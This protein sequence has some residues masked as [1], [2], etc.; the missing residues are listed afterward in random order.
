MA[1]PQLNNANIA[2]VNSGIETGQTLYLGPNTFIKNSTEGFST[3]YLPITTESVINSGLGLNINKN[4][5]SSSLVISSAGHVDTIGHIT[6]QGD[7][8]TSSTVYGN[9]LNINNGKATISDTGKTVIQDDLSIGSSI[10]LTKA[11]GEIWTAGNLI[12]DGTLSIGSTTNS[13]GTVTIGNADPNSYKI[14]LM[15]TGE[16]TAKGDLFIGSN[17]T[18]DKFVVSAISGNVL[19]HGS[20]TALDDLTIGQN[21]FIVDASTGDVSTQGHITLSSSG[22]DRFTVNS[23]SGDVYARGNL[24]IGDNKFNVNSSTGAAITQ[25]DLSI[26][27]NGVNKF[28][29]DSNDGAI[30]GHTS[31]TMKNSSETTMFALNGADINMGTSAVNGKIVTTFD[32][33]VAPP[34]A[35][36]IST[37]DYSADFNSSTSNILTTQSYV[38]KAIWEQTKRI[39][40][41]VGSNDTSLATFSNMFNMAQ[42]LAGNDAVQTLNGLLDTTGE[43]KTSITTVM[44]RAYNPIAVNC[45]PAVWADECPP[46]PIPSS[47]SGSTYGLDGWYFRNLTLPSGPS[48]INW[49]LPSNGTGMKV[50]HILN[51]FLNIYAVSDKSLPFIS[52]MTAP[53]GNN[54]DLFP[55]LCNSLVNFY[56]SASSPSA[57][58]KKSYTLYTSQNE[59]ANVFNSIKLRC[60]QTSAKNGTN[61]TQNNG[62]GSITSVSSTT[63]FLNSFDTSIVSPEDTVICF[64]VQT[65]STAATNDVELVVNSLNIESRDTTSDDSRDKINGTT[66]FMFS[67]AAV[68]TNYQFNYSFNKHI[69]FTPINGTKSGHYFKS[70]NTAF[71]I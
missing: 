8:T 56:F 25:G 54:T 67:N 44:N 66:K 52:F 50:K 24:Q 68:A 65:A 48:K 2:P 34:S 35:H 55:T 12:A 60:N 45:C 5:D 38:D 4:G 28:H 57:T 43:I 31:L 70:Y 29:V 69:D 51:L 49:Y 61:R 20:I 14:Q 13:V 3:N 27:H 1:P 21:K 59:P 6:A 36:D 39:N 46:M 19:T 62:V 53:K 16:I 17:S 22:I 11:D 9:Q 7:I 64:I 71:S 30:V 42:T 33:Y 58:A 63:S 15:N 23:S 32:S 18:S 47:I 26:Q 37:V 10:Y 41:I 40:L